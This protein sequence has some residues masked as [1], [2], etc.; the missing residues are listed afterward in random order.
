MKRKIIISVICAIVICGI[1]AGVALS[2]VIEKPKLTS[3]SDEALYTV[4]RNYGF[5]IPEELGEETKENLINGGLRKVVE[6]VEKEP[7]SYLAFSYSGIADLYE[8]VKKAV[9]KYYGIE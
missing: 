6:D 1:V 9:E 3:L 5:T 2:G 8:N 7:N 4:L